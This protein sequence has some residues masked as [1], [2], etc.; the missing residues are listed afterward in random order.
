VGAAGTI[1]SKAAGAKARLDR[2][3]PAVAS[4]RKT[5]PS[6]SPAVALTFDDG[7]DP[8]FTPAILDVLRDRDVRATFFLVGQSAAR[9]P[10]IVRRMADEGHAIGSHSTSHPDMWELGPKATLAELREGRR[11]VGEIT[12]RPVRLF[13]PPKG[14]M[15][16]IL[17]SQ[18]R[19]LGLKTWLWN[20]D[21]E[22]W[23]PGVTSQQ[24]VERTA[25][26]RGGDI[27][28]LHD[29]IER[30]IDASTT[31]RGATVAA[32]PAVIDRLQSQGLQLTALS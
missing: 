19:L 23:A 25:A 1:R 18:L 29:A 11:M 6:G 12:G 27:V 9:H 10:A 31:D 2:F 8:T 28:L 4:A 15:D 20:V 22:D 14:W 16:V 13:R 3:A 32:L 24:L 7:P 30:P 5:L 26:V 17:A 21:P